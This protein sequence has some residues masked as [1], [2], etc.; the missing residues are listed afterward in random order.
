M[1]HIWSLNSDF[2]SSALESCRFDWVHW[3]FFR[4]KICSIL[5]EN[6]FIWTLC[7][8]E[9]NVYLESAIN[10]RIRIYW[11]ILSLK[12]KNL[13][14]DIVMFFTTWMVI[15][16]NYIMG[17]QVVFSWVVQSAMN[18]LLVFC[19]NEDKRCVLSAI[20]GLICI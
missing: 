8:I 16:V 9:K 10:E 3:F 11:F 18:S 13:N 12:V 1:V 7:C 4:K 15:M 6:E 5:Y 17:K 14:P 20:M 2:K 19:F